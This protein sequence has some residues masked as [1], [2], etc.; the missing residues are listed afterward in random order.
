MDIRKGIMVRCNSD[1]LWYF[2]M[3]LYRGR[4]YANLYSQNRFS[5]IFYESISTMLHNALV[6]RCLAMS[7]S[8][9]STQSQSS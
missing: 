5:L 6:G 2:L 7:V 3:E 4:N 1:S 8:R 9:N